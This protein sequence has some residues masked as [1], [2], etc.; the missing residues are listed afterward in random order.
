MSKFVMKPQAAN[1]GSGNGEGSSITEDQWKEWNDYLYSLTD[2]VE[3]PVEGK[4][5]RYVKKY[6]SIGIL[7]FIMD[8]GFQSQSDSEYDTRCALPEEGEDNSK[9]E[10]EHIEKWPTNY[11]KWVE[12]KGVRKRK[13]YSPNRPEQEYAFFYDFP[14]IVVDW[15][16]HP[17]EDMHKLGQKPLR[18]S[19]NGRFGSMDTLVF[20]RTL[21]FRLDYKTK[22]LSNSN[23]I[24]KIASSSGVANKFVSS[25]Y[26]LGELAGTACMWN[27]EF[28]RN[29][30]DDKVYYNTKLQSHT[31]IVDV[32]VGGKVVATREEQIP[33]C[34]VPFVGIPLDDPNF[35]YSEDDLGY[36][37][38]RKE[39]VAVVSR[40]TSFKPSPVNYPDFVI[41]V[42][43]EDSTLAEALRPKGES[44]AQP[45]EEDEK[46]PDPAPT[47]DGEGSEEDPFNF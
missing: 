9:E 7:N 13:Q 26:D 32:K 1:L 8:V 16:K 40:A 4:K 21:P 33:T 42:N 43:F 46:K 14:E 15:T 45:D 18:I 31:P 12:E 47:E 3:E 36:I 28:G 17:N 41:G 10:L 23:P 29:V 34:D 39:L 30:N 2:A 6:S 35:V 37:Q 20:S 44:P 38:N 25:G 22:T 19:Y 5:N 24:Y 27:I 11:F